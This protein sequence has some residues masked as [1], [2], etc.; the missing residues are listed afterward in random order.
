MTAE[1]VDIPEAAR[2]LGVSEGRVRQLVA[3]GVL[4]SRKIN[5][6]RIPLSAIVERMQAAP[7]SG[8]PKKVKKSNGNGR[9]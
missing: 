8:R 2:I 7:Q 1:T 5:P 3:D 4:E 9:K 6:T